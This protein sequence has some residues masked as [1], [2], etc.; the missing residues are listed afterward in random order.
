MPV[1][2]FSLPSPTLLSFGDRQI[3]GVL[4]HLLPSQFLI[5][6]FYLDTHFRQEKARRRRSDLITGFPTFFFFALQL[7]AFENQKI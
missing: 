3:Q 6:H 5:S 4:T 7:W 2:C 1:V